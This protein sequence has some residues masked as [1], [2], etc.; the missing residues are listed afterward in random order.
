MPAGTTV[1]GHHC[2]DRRP[3]HRVW[4]QEQGHPHER[5]RRAAFLPHHPL[6]LA[7]IHPGSE[8]AQRLTLVAPPAHRGDVVEHRG[9]QAEHM[10]RILAPVIVG[11]RTGER[12][13]LSQQVRQRTGAA[14]LPHGEDQAA[15]HASIREA[16]CAQQ[17]PR[18]RSENSKS[19][20]PNEQCRL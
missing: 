4:P 1:A 9:D 18:V 8:G 17:K 15:V 12:H 19:L 16:R 10:G 11:D 20:I 6:Q 2:R 3:Q 7:V 14:P 13:I 5:A